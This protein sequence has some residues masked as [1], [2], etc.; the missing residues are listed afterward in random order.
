MKA[1]D[2]LAV[3]H[4]V[5][6][7]S[8]PAGQKYGMFFGEDRYTTKESDRLVRLPL[9]YGITEADQSKVIE[10]VLQFYKGK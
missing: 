7:H 5:P 2:V 8:A 4:Y 6:L 1:N 3:F 10:T 9:Y